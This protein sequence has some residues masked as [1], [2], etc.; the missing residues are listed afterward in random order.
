MN[1]IRKY[2]KIILPLAI[3]LVGFLAAKTLI[4]TR[5]KVERLVV[6]D[7]GL[8]VRV[9][10]AERSSRSVTVPSQGTVEPRTEITLVA[11]VPGKVVSASGSLEEGRFFRK[12]EVL[13]RIDPRDYELAVT[14]A[15]GQVAQAEVRL[16]MEEAE[17]EVARSEWKDLGT[18]DGS[19]LA[20]REPQ[21]AEARAAV[22]T[23]G[24]ALAKAELD[25]ERT[26][27][28]AP[29]D[30]RVRNRLAD[31]GQF[32]GRGTAIARVYAVDYVEIRLPLPDEEIAFLD[33]PLGFSAGES[34]PAVRLTAGVAGRNPVWEGRIV[35]AEGEI[36][37]MSRMVSVVA[38]VD[39]PYG[40]AVG[41][42]GIPLAVGLFVS[43]EIE[44]RQLDDVTVLPRE[45][46]RPGNRVFLVDDGRL[47]FRDVEIVR[48]DRDEVIVGAGLTAGDLVCL[49]PLDT[50][51]DGMKVRLHSTDE[52]RPE[53]ME[54]IGSALPADGA[55][56]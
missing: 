3:L 15:R 20:L 49:T 46:L 5:P 16:V 37:P 51:V 53:K 40:A 54:T 36:D 14:A 18:G 4:A 7:S 34:G 13:L 10:P 25:L 32:V 52:D 44:G 30:G 26:V 9:V 28:G 8:L 33:L 38:R 39:D 41:E 48:T 47:R 50:P 55:D 29:F 43:A 12:G 11:E 1:W 31:E 19:P 56:R 21:L 2:R 35:R 27:I 23:A 45:A 22:A 24:A 17:A 42:E 6:N